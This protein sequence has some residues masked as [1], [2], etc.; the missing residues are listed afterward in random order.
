ML[1]MNKPR[2][3]LMKSLHR[4]I[5]G[6][7]TRAVSIFEQ[8]SPLPEASQISKF[9]HIRTGEKDGQAV[10]KFYWRNRLILAM[11]TPRFTGNG[12]MLE[13]KFVRFL[14]QRRIQFMRLEYLDDGERVIKHIASSVDGERKTA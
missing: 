14:E 5:N 6:E 1:F 11:T 4:E 2:D 9:I 13:V 8:P 10:S 12:K 3:V 7:L